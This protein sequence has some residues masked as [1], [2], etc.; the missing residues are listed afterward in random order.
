MLAAKQRMNSA[1]SWGGEPDTATVLRGFPT[2]HNI[3]VLRPQTSRSSFPHFV[4]T[5]NPDYVIPETVF[6][7]M[8]NSQIWKGTRLS[9]FIFNKLNRGPR[10]ATY[11]PFVPPQ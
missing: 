7:L 5:Q 10:I 6:F 11:S 4:Y 9:L 2:R 3:G 8:E 1:A